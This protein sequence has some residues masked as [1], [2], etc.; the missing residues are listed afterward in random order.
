METGEVHP[1]P[2][3]QH[4]QAGDKIQRLEDD[5]RRAVPVRGLKLIPD[6]SVRRERQPLS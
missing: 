4:R 3:Y 6:V 5:V 2:G 1:G